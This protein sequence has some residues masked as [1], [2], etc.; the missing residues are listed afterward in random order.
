MHC[1]T[2]IVGGG[3]AGL[4]CAVALADRGVDV[5]V[6]E[7][8]HRLGGRAGSVL[9]AA[10][11]DL[12]DVGPHVL[13]TAYPNMLHLLD[14]LGTRDRIVWDRDQLITLVDQRRLMRI[15]P[16]M[17]PAPFHLLP[18]L[19][20]V[21]SIGIS[22]LLSNH[23]TS[24]FVVSASARDLAHIDDVDAATF[25]RSMKSS[26]RFIEWFWATV[27]MAIMNV[28]LEQCSA[29]ALMR[30]YRILLA[31]ADLRLGYADTALA[32]L[33]APQAAQR[34]RARGGRVVTGAEVRALSQCGGA[35]DGALLADGRRITART[36]VC[37]VEPQRLARLMPLPWR[38][39]W[40][41]FRALHAF[42]PSPYICTYLWFDRKLGRERNW[43]RCWS[44][45]TV[46]YDSY[47]LSN[48]R[49]GWHQRPSV[50]ASNAI[51]SSR[52]GPTSDAEI[53]S[54]TVREIA[55]VL[56]RAAPARLLHA[57]VHRVPMAIPCPHPGVERLRPPV[58]TPVP[59]LY[60]A[61]DWVDTGLP[62]SME[63]AVRSGW[64]AAERILG[65]RGRQ[66]HLAREVRTSIAMRHRA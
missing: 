47:D 49:R 60:L 33:F 17:L 34:I 5:I 12:V 38:S 65:D 8:S 6:A 26:R 1:D 32:E 63:S 10:T 64:L 41:G 21:P 56:P 36:C 16:S 44:R 7:R 40:Q 48:I 42:R 20:R 39:R 18:S 59:A 25:L 19:M 55:E 61:G 58:K 23:R 11:G 28:P 14:L 37:A 66:H 53:V 22:D 51:F 45:R 15:R 13:L 27:C 46:N 43:A 50:I 52:L 2:L 3:L 54:A 24:R 29:G 57:R 4:A 9:D 31:N 62:A 35:V 30:F